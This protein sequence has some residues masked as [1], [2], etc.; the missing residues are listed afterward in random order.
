VRHGAQSDSARH[1][2][3]HIP[4]GGV[5]RPPEH[6][7]PLLQRVPQAP[8]WA[9]SVCVLTHEPPHEVVPDAQPQLPPEHPVPEG[10]GLL[11]R[12]QWSVLEVV[13]VSHPLAALLSQLSRGAVH[14]S[15]GVSG[16]LR[17]GEGR[18]GSAVASMVTIASS[19]AHTQA[20]KVPSSW[21]VRVP[22][23][24]LAHMQSSVAPAVQPV[25]DGPP[26]PPPRAP[27]HET[28]RANTRA[29]HRWRVMAATVRRLSRV[30]HAGDRP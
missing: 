7:S 11:Q 30:C 25:G 22:E 26:E 15:P 12:P 2:D 10:Q 4:A 28:S 19:P 23:A 17:S 27:P 29:T 1:D 20:A 24:P 6:V 16:T 3:G 8:Q 5:Q 21:Q 14:V 18:S 9:V 13:S